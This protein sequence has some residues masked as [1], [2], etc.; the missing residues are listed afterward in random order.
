MNFDKREKTKEGLDTRVRER[1][2]RERKH[3]YKECKLFLFGVQICVQKC[4]THAQED[5]SP[6]I[7]IY[8]S[9]IYLAIVKLSWEQWVA[10]E[11]CL[12]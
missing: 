1:Q 8:N 5:L 3:K 10:M 12:L 7:Y 4:K 11:S 2:Q 6:Y 9:C